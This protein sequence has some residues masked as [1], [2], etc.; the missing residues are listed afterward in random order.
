MK[1]YILVISLF[2]SQLLL[3]QTPNKGEK[4][5]KEL[6]Q[7]YKNYPAMSIDFELQMQNKAEGINEKSKGKAWVKGNRYKLDVMGVETY[8]DGQQQWTYLKEVQEVNLSIPDPEDENTLSPS[9]LLSSYS[10]GYKIVYQNEMFQY[11][12]ALQI[13]NLFPLDDKE[14]QFKRITLKID[15]DKKQLFQV[16]RQGKD[17]NDY[18]ITLTSIK[19]ETNINDDFFTFDVKKHP[20]AELIDLR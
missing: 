14:S 18:T 12:R 5:I 15:K 13:I 20:E 6:A 8:F 7:K 1:N 16:V 9:K 19:K 17:G 11:H 3:A 4:L 2:I 10:E